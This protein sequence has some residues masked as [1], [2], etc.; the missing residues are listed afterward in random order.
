MVRKTSAS[1]S[2]PPPAHSSDVRHATPADLPRIVELNHLVFLG[3]VDPTAHKGY[4]PPMFTRSNV[5]NLVVATRGD[6]VVSHVGA[7]PETMVIDG[8]DIPVTCIGGVC[9]HPSWR[10]GG[11]AGKALAVAV[12]DARARG[13]VLMPI[14]GRRTLYSRIGAEPVGPIH[15]LTV[16]RERL[17]EGRGEVADPGDVGDI[18]DLHADES[19]GYRWNELS[20]PTLARSRGDGTD[21]GWIRRTRDG[22]L[23]AWALIRKVN[24]VERG[25]PNAA[26]LVDAIGPPRYVEQLCA[27][28]LD[29]GDRECLLLQLSWHQRELIEHF[30]RRCARHTI[31]LS[32]YHTMKLLSPGCLIERLADRFAPVAPR[33]DGDALTLTLPAG[34]VTLRNE[35]L[36]HHVL[37][38]PADYWPDDLDAPPGLAD[39]VRALGPLGKS[40]LP[41]PL[42]DYGINYV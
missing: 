15:E 40:P 25:W 34:G 14:S 42:P 36:M 31:E 13:D 2:S 35:R 27:A 5:E 10:G 33:L 17:G 22:Q 9:T 26:V 20:F 38:T 18:I 11:L 28:M 29:A 8:A 1:M 21:K 19:I 32:Q 3:R 16:F 24:P 39:A 6:E 7:V 4:H 12:D 37:L 30:D 23:R 41:V